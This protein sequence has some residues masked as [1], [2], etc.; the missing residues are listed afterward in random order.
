MA[1]G[2]R[3]E[4]WP[5]WKPTRRWRGSLFATRRM[6]FEQNPTHCNGRVVCPAC[7]YPTIME[8]GGFDS[9]YLCHWE[10]DGHD[11]PY[12]QDRNGGPNDSTLNRARENF[13]QTFSVWSFEERDQFSLWNEARLFDPR[14]LQLKLQIRA[15]YDDLM[16]LQAA[17]D[18][19]RQ[20][21]EIK[22]LRENRSQ[23]SQTV[24]DEVTQN[25]QQEDS[26][27]IS[28]TEGVAGT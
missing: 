24:A 23:V 6:F 22:R 13:E 2:W 21:K 7:R 19:A 9:C 25:M 12:A 18:V 28:I 20:W 1:R 3:R 17:S 15:A 14:I 26:N 16:N 11:D 27:K 10:D 4:P 8:R 5:D